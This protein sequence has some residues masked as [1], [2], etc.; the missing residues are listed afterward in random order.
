MAEINKEKP[1][2]KFFIMDLFTH[3]FCKL[4]IIFTIQISQ[5]KIR[6][7]MFYSK[8]NSHVIVK[9]TLR[10]P[11]FLMFQAFHMASHQ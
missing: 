4:K 3:T 7:N 2:L 11:K 9:Q 1:V 8:K 5:Y 6:H 10:G